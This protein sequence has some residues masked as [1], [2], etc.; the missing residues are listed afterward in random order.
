MSGGHGIL[1]YGDIMAENYSFESEYGI[2]NITK[3]SLTQLIK[4]V[5]NDLNQGVRLA[6]KKEVKSHGKSNIEVSFKEDDECNIKV[7]VVVD[8]G[9]SISGVTYNIISEIKNR[10]DM[11][12]ERIKINITVTIVGIKSKQTAKRNIE[13]S[14]FYDVSE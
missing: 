14:R 10:M 4:D 5:L 8:F 1:I 9:T 2:I 12:L 6:S 11:I 3:T 13:V 7:F